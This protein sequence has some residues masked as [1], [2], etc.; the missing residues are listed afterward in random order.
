MRELPRLVYCRPSGSGEI[1]R[2][3]C[4]PSNRGKYEEEIPLPRVSKGRRAR[5][6][7]HA[8]RISLL[9]SFFLAWVVFDLSHVLKRQ[10][11]MLMQGTKV[12]S[13]KEKVKGR[14]VFLFQKERKK[15]IKI[16]IY[17]HTMVN[18]TA[19]FIK[20]NINRLLKR[21]LF[22]IELL[23]LKNIIKS[24]CT[25]TQS[26]ACNCQIHTSSL[27]FMSQIKSATIYQESIK[28]VK[29]S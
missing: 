14:H 9:F 21:D 15:R 24:D 28:P 17:F 4:L 22:S 18:I 12:P 6:K 2:R 7:N 25:R 10:K 3:S 1:T 11:K 8:R 23:Y 16:V 20:L 19:V 26:K 27:K 5:G 13:K 29:P